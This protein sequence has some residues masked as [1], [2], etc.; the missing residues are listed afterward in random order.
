M[1]SI[2]LCLV[3]SYAVMEN[4]RLLLHPVPASY[5][6][7]FGFKMHVGNVSYF[8]GGSGYVMSKAALIALVEEQILKDT[9]CHP[10]DV[11]NEDI[12]V[13]AYRFFQFC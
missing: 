13:G 9:P 5:P 10:G 11:G 6:I 4:M 1:D 8:S 12:P 7:A 3:F 2:D